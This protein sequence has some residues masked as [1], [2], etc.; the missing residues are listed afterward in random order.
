MAD[1]CTK[2]IKC[3]YHVTGHREAVFTRLR[4]KMWACDYCSKKNASIWRAFL[5]QRL[6]DISSEWWLVTLTASS[7]TRGAL[8]SLTNIRDNL[9]RLYKRI[10]AV[11][12]S[13]E[14]VR[15]YERHPS[16]L[17]IHA[18]LIMSGLAPYVANGFS[19]KHRPMAIGVS[20]RAARCGYWSVRTW[21]KK[22]CQE[23]GMG[24]IVDVKLL[25]GEVSFAVWYVTKYLTKSQQDLHVP[26][27]RHVQTSGG[28]GGPKTEKQEWKTCAYI[29]SEMFQAGTR[30]IDLNTGFVV[31]NNFWEEK[32]NTFYPKE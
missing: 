19:V 14:F 23:C 6:P 26:Y 13:I 5:N 1:Y 30:V 32:G 18:H 28:I 25:T 11:F 31:D 9:E 20:S 12:G 16:S 8:E 2:Y 7:L 15:V 4:C 24:Y 27:L 21:F 10:K 29:T 3:A 17:A 22:V